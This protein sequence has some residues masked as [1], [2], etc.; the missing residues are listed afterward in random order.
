M[1]VQQQGL[2]N[3]VPSCLV[4]LHYFVGFSHM[5]MRNYGEAT[6]IF[7]NCL[8][9]VQHTQNVGHHHQGQPQK[10]NAKYDVVSVRCGWG[11]DWS[12]LLRLLADREDQRANLPSPGSVLFV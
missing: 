12:E 1:C 4:T 10:R 2:Y 11:V 8:L 3:T 7:I 9:Y 6:K 5:M